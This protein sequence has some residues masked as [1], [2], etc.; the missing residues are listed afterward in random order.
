MPAQSCSHS[1]KKTKD[2]GKEADGGDADATDCSEDDE[3]D[4]DSEE[5][6]DREGGE[7]SDDE[8]PEGVKKAAAAM[9]VGVGNLSDPENCQVPF[10]GS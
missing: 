7:E 5:E 2:G 6:E 3:D 8:E 9:A 10:Y 1:Q 4:S